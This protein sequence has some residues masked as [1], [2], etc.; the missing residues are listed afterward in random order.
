MLVP[1]ETVRKLAEGILLANGVPV[2]GLAVNG[3]GALYYFLDV[4]AGATHLEFRTSGGTGDL[5][6]ALHQ[7]SAGG[8]AWCFDNGAGDGESQSERR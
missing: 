4:P 8:Q 6:M 3:H 1:V 7:D 5:V 2:Q